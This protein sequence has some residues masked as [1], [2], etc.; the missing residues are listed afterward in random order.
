VLKIDIEGAEFIFS[1]D[2][3]AAHFL[4][5]VRFPALETYEA[6]ETREQILDT[7]RQG[8]FEMSFHSE[9]L[10]VLI[11]GESK[12]ATAGETQCRLQ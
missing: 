6:K 12:T 5:K 4:S 9:P 10:S 8:E 1:R 7:L 3:H 11:G 2:T